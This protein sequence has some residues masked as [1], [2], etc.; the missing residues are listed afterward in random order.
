M[1][2]IYSTNVGK[3]IYDSLPYS[4]T[5]HNYFR[6]ESSFLNWF[7]FDMSIF[8]PNPDC[9]FGIS[10]MSNVFNIFSWNIA[11]EPKTFLD[12]WHWESYRNNIFFSGTFRLISRYFDM[13]GYKWWIFPSQHQVGTSMKWKL[14]EG[15]SL[16]VMDSFGKDLG[17]VGCF[18]NLGCL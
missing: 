17:P 16:A 6:Q 7:N 18:L 4:F 1:L 9:L 3:Q 12:T 14:S 5:V 2:G 8:C 11:H 15:L 10:T 13:T